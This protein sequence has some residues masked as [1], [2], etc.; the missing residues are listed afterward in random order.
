MTRDMRQGAAP[1]GDAPSTISPHQATSVPEDSA[2]LLDE[3]GTDDVDLGAVLDE[4]F[5]GDARQRER[6]TLL[7]LEDPA[8]GAGLFYRHRVNWLAGPTQSGKSWVACVLI[9]RAL[10]EG[11]DVAYLDCESDSDAASIVGRLRDLG[12]GRDDIKT[13]LTYRRPDSRR[14]WH[15]AIGSLLDRDLDVVVIDGVMEALRLAGAKTGDTDDMA[16]WVRTG[17]AALARSTRAGVLCVDHTARDGGVAGS[18]H[19]LRTVGG[20][21]Y[22]LEAERRLGDRQ[23]GV[24][25][26]RVLKDRSGGL[27]LRTGE[28]AGRI[29]LDATAGDGTIDWSA[30]RDA[31][32]C[33]PSATETA[34][35]GAPRVTAPVERREDLLEAVS[36]ALETATE[37]LSGNKIEKAV[38]GTAARVREA[39]EVLVREN[40]VARDE[41]P[42]IGKAKPTHHHR[43]LKSYGSPAARSSSPP[44]RGVGGRTTNGVLTAPTNASPNLDEPPT[45]PTNPSS[46]VADEPPTNRRAPTNPLAVV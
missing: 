9:A 31:T 33:R 8:D 43:L 26:L 15:S 32:A 1:S 44:L 35:P 42:A 12:A 37:P 19:K 34:E 25:A 20:A 27:G 14:S 18:F 11:Y 2:E 45:N 6:P 3:H 7:E 5:A 41:V 21:A 23:R 28:I 4:V 40:Y 29:V 17:P 46:S 39:L 38:G 22:T 36:R 10:V 16:D 13:C 30:V 24:L